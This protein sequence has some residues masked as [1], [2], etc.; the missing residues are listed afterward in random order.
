M[1]NL[2]KLKLANR[3]TITDTLGNSVEVE[4]EKVY[5]NTDEVVIHKYEFET[6]RGYIKYE[7]YENDESME[8][9]MP[10]ANLR[11]CKEFIKEHNLKLKK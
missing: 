8:L 6:R 9:V 10:F 5:K 4:K 2:E 7:L 11:E 3:I 1:G